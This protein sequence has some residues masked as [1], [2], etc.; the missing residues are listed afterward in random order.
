MNSIS[1]WSIARTASNWSSRGT[2]CPMTVWDSIQAPIFLPSN[3][4]PVHR[5]SSLADCFCSRTGEGANKYPSAGALISS[6]LWSSFR[7]CKF[8]VAVATTALDSS[9]LAPRPSSPRLEANLI[10]PKFALAVV[11]AEVSCT[12]WRLRSTDSSDTRT[13]PFDT[14]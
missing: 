8:P 3:G 5:L 12:I 9:S 11:C 1:F 10:R 7:C 14:R 4:V 6:N 2:I 13:C